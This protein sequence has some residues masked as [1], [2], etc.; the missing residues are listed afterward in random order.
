MASLQESRDELHRKV[1][2]WS[3]ELRQRD[4]R[5]THAYGMVTGCWT[6]VEQVMQQAVGVAVAVTPNSASILSEL[7][8]DR[9]ISDLSLGQLAVVLE[10]CNGALAATKQDFMTYDDHRCLDRLVDERNESI[11]ADYEESAAKSQQLL[12]RAAEFASSDMLESLIDRKR[13]L[14]R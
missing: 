4:V 1:L 5:S 9:S 6:L 8:F 10:R 11:H 12:A 3:V 14:G 2:R 13:Q 7:R